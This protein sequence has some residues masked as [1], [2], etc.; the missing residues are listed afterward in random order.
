MEAESLRPN[1]PLGEWINDDDDN[2]H[3]VLKVSNSNGWQLLQ[4]TFLSKLNATSPSYF[5]LRCVRGPEKQA[6][7]TYGARKLGVG[8]ASCFQCSRDD[9][10]IH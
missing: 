9:L 7:R 8:C 4:L 3:N 6:Q 2:D 1:S 10:S 5:L